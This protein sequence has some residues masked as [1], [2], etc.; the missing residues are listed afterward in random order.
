MADHK[1]ENV[2]ESEDKNDKD[3]QDEAGYKNKRV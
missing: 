2:D 1:N 3:D